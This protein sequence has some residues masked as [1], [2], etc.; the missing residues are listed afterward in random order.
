MIELS[1]DIDDFTKRLHGLTFREI[2]AISKRT[3]GQSSNALWYFY[4]KSIITATLTKRISSSE[5]ENW[6]INAAITKIR[7]VQ[8]FY[9]S[10]RFGRDNEKN[11]IQSFMRDFRKR[12]YNAEYSQPGLR[13]HP[14]YRFIGGSCDALLHCDCC[15]PTLL[16][17]KCAYSLRDTKNIKKD[18]KQ[19]LFLI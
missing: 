18:A 1:N 9:P 4:R 2:N 10:I 5:E 3:E 15:G 14:K 11:G 8:L 12:H 13:L 17:V 6:K 7:S 16:E 19:P